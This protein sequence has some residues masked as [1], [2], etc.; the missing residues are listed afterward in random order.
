MA[1]GNHG[2][3]PLAKALIR[4]THHQTVQGTAVTFDGL[5]NLFREHF[6]AG[7][8]DA[9]RATAEQGNAAIGVNRGKVP[10]EHIALAVNFTD[11]LR[12]LFRVLVVAEHRALGRDHPHFPRPSCDLLIVVIEHFDVWIEFEPGG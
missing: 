5:F 6:F 2:H 9:H 1:P 8:I 10:G 3:H 11:S 7:G 4:H 12:G